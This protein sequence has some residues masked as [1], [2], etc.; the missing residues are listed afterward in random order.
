MNRTIMITEKDMNHF[1]NIF[2]LNYNCFKQICNNIDYVSDKNIVDIYGKAGDLF[3]DNMDKII[4]IMSDF[5]GELL[6]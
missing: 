4:N 2:R 5:G 6:E 3:E 1:N